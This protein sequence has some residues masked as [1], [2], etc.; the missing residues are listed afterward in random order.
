MPER[1]V[2]EVSRRVVSTRV[3][4][5]ANPV[6]KWGRE[7]KASCMDSIGGFFVGLLLFF[8]TFALPY[9][10]ATT[11]KDS[12]D[13]SRLSVVPA[14]DVVNT[15]GKALVRG[16]LTTDMPVVPPK[17]A[18]PRVLAFKYIVEDY[19]THPVKHNETHTE[20]QGGKEV[21]VT[22]EVTEMVSE[23]VAKPEETKWAQLKLG[24]I[25][26][27]PNR[28]SMQNMPWE[29]A[30]KTSNQQ[31]T[32]REHVDVLR[33]GLT[34]L[35]ATQLTGGQVAT[36][37]DFYIVT[38]HTKDELVASLGRAEEGQRWLLIIAS[39]VLWTIAFNLL[40]GPAMILL[41]ILP[42]KAIGAAVRGVYTFF[43][44]ICACILTWTTYVAVRYWWLIIVVLAVAAVVVMVMTNKHRHPAPEMDV[45]PEPPAEPPAPS[46]PSS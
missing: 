41:N 2:R 14:A 44:F 4:G 7:S 13:I 43:A 1:Q 34:V 19:V 21:E 16:E 38:T 3:L 8:V 39:V 22:E 18:A 33:P 36:Q 28:A 29:E 45:A 11:E 37:P 27:D 25:T 5:S 30:W 31:D 26:I 9:C 32:H 46:P 23:W 12:K 10:A 40:I 6:A 20:V 35:L 17:G 24:G 42:V 15:T